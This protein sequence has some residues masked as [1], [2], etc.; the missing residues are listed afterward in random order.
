MAVELNPLPSNSINN[1]DT[2]FQ[3]VVEALD[4]AVSR[5]GNTPNQMNSDLDMNSND[6]LNGGVGNFTDIFVDSVP[7]NEVVGIQGPVG[8]QG[9][10]GNTGPQ[11]P[12]GDQGPIGQ[13]LD[14]DVQ[15]DDLIARAAYDNEAE[16]FRVLVSDDGTG[17]AI[18]SRVSATP[19]VWSDPAYIGTSSEAIIGPASSVSGNFP[20]FSNT[21]GKIVQDSGVPSV[22][23]VRVDTAQS[24]SSGEQTQARDNIDAASNDDISNV[25][26][27]ITTLESTRAYNI[28]TRRNRIVNH[29]MRVSQEN[30]TTSGTTNGRYP[31]DQWAQYFVTS[32]GTLTVAQVASVTPAGS[33]NRLRATVTVADASLAAG[34]FWTLTQN[35]EG[36]N[37][38]DFMYGSA[39]AQDCVLRFGFKGPAGTYA[40]HLGNSAANRSYV[41]LFTIGAGEANTDTVQTLSIPGDTTGTWLTAD[42]VIGITLDIVLACGSTF[43]GSTGWQ[44]GNILGTSGVSN[45]MGTGSSVFELFDVGLRLDPDAT[46]VYGQY[47]VGEKHPD[48]RA[49]RYTKKLT[50]VP[51]GYNVGAAGRLYDG[52]ILL[53]VPM[54]KPPVIG[55]GAFTVDAGSPGTVAFDPRYPVTNESFQFYNSSGT[56]PSS[57]SVAVSAVLLARLS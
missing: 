26:V 20:S 15:V 44:A 16:G 1:I 28:D 21:T 17:A 54:A 53:S 6:I 7:I 22:K 14:F 38:A 49:E 11:G 48:Y 39:S 27:S 3:R 47:Q 24:F 32:A 10:T 12:Q 37:V 9:P 5:S 34:E 8:P 25:G 18:Y 56:W 42:G 23:V 4:D 35:L 52:H 43:Q 55:S 45:G 57:T 36:S 41:A 29:D 51:L 31:V 19:G 13:G 2:N 40:V 30:G 46:G 50:S 33:P